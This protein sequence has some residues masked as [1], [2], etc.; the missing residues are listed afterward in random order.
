VYI[1]VYIYTYKKV[2]IFFQHTAHTLRAKAVNPF[3]S[4]IHVKVLYN[5]SN[6]NTAASNRK[7]PIEINANDGG[8]T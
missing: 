4:K 6:G 7:N 5:F 3:S 8:A 2:Y 1:Y